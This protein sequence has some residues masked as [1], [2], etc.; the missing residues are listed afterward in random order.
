[1]NTTPNYCSKWG[2]GWS[3]KNSPRNIVSAIQNGS[4]Q[5][6]CVGELRDE[7]RDRV[8][9]LAENRGIDLE[10]ERVEEEAESSSENSSKDEE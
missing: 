5:K 2:T 1:M 6:E 3:K 4:V 8:A 7:K 9:E 10:F